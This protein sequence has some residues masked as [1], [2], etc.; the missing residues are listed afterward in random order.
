MFNIVTEKEGTAG[1]VLIRAL[2]P[3]HG[4]GLMK[5]YRKTEDIIQLSNGP[6]KLTRA[7]GIDRTHNRADLAGDEL[8]VAHGPAKKHVIARGSRIGIKQGLEK[9]WRFW[10]KGNG[11]VSVKN[12]K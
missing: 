2:E 1:A 7:L 4:I 3:K 10:I 5:K 9:K 6:G 8:Y 12:K 11:F